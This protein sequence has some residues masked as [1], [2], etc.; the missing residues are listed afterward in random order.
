MGILQGKKGIVFGVANEQSIAF[1]CA[2][3]A[4]EQGAEVGITYF[5]SPENYN[6]FLKEAV[7]KQDFAFSI[8]CDATKKEELESTFKT[9]KEKFGNLDFVV[10]SMAMAKSDELGKIR[11]KD[12]SLEGY[13]LALH[14]SAY[15]LLSISKYAA[16]LMKEGGCITTMSYYGA[17]KVIPNY[18]IMGV[19]KASLESITRYLAA[20]LGKERIR[21]NTISPGPILTRAAS[22][23]KGFDE[24]LELAEKKAPLGRTVT[25]DEVG[26]ANCFLC[27]DMATGITGE[28]LYVDGGANIIGI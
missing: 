26:Y 5:M 21:V 2:R 3:I 18:D 20:D 8:N 22:G 7:D 16:E 13:Q 11:F 25:I 23:I 27:S 1:A 14:V 19:A 28:I 17:E 24:L 4:K 10:H 12:T 6:R 9:V 15:T